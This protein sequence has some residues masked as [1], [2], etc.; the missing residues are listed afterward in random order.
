MGSQIERYYE[1]YIN[2]ENNEDIDENIFTTSYNNDENQLNE[3]FTDFESL[4][5]QKNSNSSIEKVRSLKTNKIYARKK[6]QNP[7]L[8]KYYSEQINVLKKINHPYII[9]YLSY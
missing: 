2:S 3:Q 1:P 4:G 7:Q 8:Y 5:E 6:I 9:K